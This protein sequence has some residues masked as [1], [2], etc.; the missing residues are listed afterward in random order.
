MGDSRAY[1]V[2]R[3]TDATVAY[4]Q[5][6]RL[7]G[8]L[9]LR[10]G[11]AGL[12]AELRTVRDVRRMAAL[13]PQARFDYKEGARTDPVTGAEQWFELDV[14]TA[15]DTALEAE[16]PLDMMEDVPAGTVEDRFVSVLGQGM[17]AIDWHGTWPDDPESGSYGSPKYDG[18]QVVFHGDSPDW[19][20][21]TEHHT[22]FV[23]VD[24][25]GALHRARRL[26]AQIGSS[27]QGEPQ[28][29]W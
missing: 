20:R 26:A 6:Q 17:A 25:S 14:R 27:V 19:G 21:R 5:A 8:L 22:V 13:L 23:H 18:V 10:E 12:F 7:R 2:F 3:T 1:P 15:D 29:G 28:T 9:E 4:T 24:K 11:K 16:L